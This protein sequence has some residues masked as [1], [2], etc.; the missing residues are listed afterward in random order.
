MFRHTATL[1]DPQTT[2]VHAINGAGDNITLKFEFRG[3]KENSAIVV[4]YEHYNGYITE[5]HF[6]NIVTIWL[7]EN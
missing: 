1:I 4:W 5:V 7:Q 2:S 3:Y 6:I